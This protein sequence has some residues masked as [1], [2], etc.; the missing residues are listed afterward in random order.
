MN[1]ADRH[2]PWLAAIGDRDLLVE[3]IEREGTHVFLGGQRRRSPA[4]RLLAHREISPTGC[5]LWTGA[6]SQYGYGW[7]SLRG[8]ALVA[9]RVSYELL[10]GPIP[11]GCQLDHLCHNEDPTCAGGHTC[12]HRKCI[13]PAHLDACAAPENVYRGLEQRRRHLEWL[14]SRV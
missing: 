7:T 2:A 9:H 1:G 13:N 5:W 3:H 8:R 14:A 6:T 11:S 12:L 10:V 4:V